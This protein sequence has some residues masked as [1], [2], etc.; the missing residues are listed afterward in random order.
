MLYPPVDVDNLPF[1]ETKKNYFMTA[2]R[3]VPYKRIDLIVKAFARMPERRLIV[4]GD[5]PERERIETAARGYKNIEILGYQGNAELN[6]L[7]RRREHLYLQQS[8]TLGLP[9]WRPKHVLA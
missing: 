9:P 6:Q 5:G 7:C 3:L 1:S 8:R 2:S 4:V